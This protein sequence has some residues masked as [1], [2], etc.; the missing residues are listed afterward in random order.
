[1]KLSDKITSVTTILTVCIGSDQLLKQ[2]AKSILEYSPPI[3]FL[4]DVVRFQYAENRGMMLSIGATLPPG[5]RFWVFVIAVGVLLAGMLV[6]VLWKGDMERLQTVS[7][8][9]IVSGGFSNLIDRI[10]RNG[11][12]IDYVSVGFGDVRTAV[13]NLA[14]VLVFVG[15][16]VIVIQ[17]RGKRHMLDDVPPA[18]TEAE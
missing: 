17:R 1:M 10:L 6:Y 13:F 4:D 3:S 16:F 2:V 9:L 12:V 18:D 8:S 11:V 5:V 15:V 14:D 7:W